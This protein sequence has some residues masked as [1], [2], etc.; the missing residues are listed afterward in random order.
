MCVNALV[1]EWEWLNLRV[2]ALKLVINSLINRMVG[3]FNDYNTGKSQFN[4]GHGVN[5]SR[6][7]S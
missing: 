4:S 1:R 7:L 2:Y 5:E 6:S 3:E